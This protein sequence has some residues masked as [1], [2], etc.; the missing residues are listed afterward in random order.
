MRILSIYNVWLWN[1]TLILLLTFL[2]MIFFLRA[3]IVCSI[4][5]G[6]FSMQF[7]LIIFMVL[8]Y[9]LMVLKFERV[10][11]LSGSF[12]IKGIGMA[13]CDLSELYQLFVIASFIMC[14]HLVIWFF[15]F[16][17]HVRPLGTYM[18]HNIIWRPFWV[19]FFK[20]FPVF[21]TEVDVGREWFFRTQMFSFS[22]HIRA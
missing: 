8:I 11:W 5:C 20:L 13:I 7:K 6:R 21:L 4:F 22:S 10:R 3:L 16:L 17:I 19:L 1:R 14:R 2:L 15:L 18:S 12:E 9:L